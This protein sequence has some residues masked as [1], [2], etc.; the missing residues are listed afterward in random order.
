[1]MMVVC[2]AWA[3]QGV[4]MAAGTAAVV[5]VVGRGVCFPAQEVATA[6]VFLVGW[7][8]CSLAR[9]LT[10]ELTVMMRASVRIGWVGGVLVVVASSNDQGVGRRRAVRQGSSV[11]GLGSDAENGVRWGMGR[12]NGL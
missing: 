2:P 12:E 5:V 7:G 3:A 8:A 11:L 4:V 1:M 6:A 10:L 9:T